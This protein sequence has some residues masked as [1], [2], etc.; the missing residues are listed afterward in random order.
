MKIST[1]KSLGY[2]IPAEWEPHE[3]TWLQWPQDK[4]YKGYE[5]K[6]ERI[7]MNMVE[8]LHEYETVHII[9]SGEK[10]RDHIGDQL[11]SY[12]NRIHYPRRRIKL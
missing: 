11:H 8:A 3:G 5:L 9:V 4:V 2:R 12:S 10:Q 1:P 6:L 7:W